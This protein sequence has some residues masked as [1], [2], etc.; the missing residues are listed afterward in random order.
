MSIPQPHYAQRQIGQIAVD[1]PGA[2]A[3][4][5]R[6][7]LDY[8]CG[9]QMSL[10]EAAR[11][12]SIDLQV[13][14]QELAGLGPQQPADH[15]TDPQALIDYIISRFHDAH[16]RDLPELIALSA[17]VERV[18]AGHAEVPVGLS[19]LLQSML[20]ELNLH[21]EKEERILFPLMRQNPGG[22][23]APPIARMREEHED[24]GHLLQQLQQLTHDLHLPA[25]A[26]TTWRALYTGLDRFVTDLMT[27]I[28]T[29]NQVLFPQFEQM[30]AP[31][32]AAH[33][34]AVGGEE[35][36]HII[37]QPHAHRRADNIYP[38][39]ASGIA[40][41]FRHAAIFGA[42]DA[43]E[44]GETMAFFNDHDPLPL[45]RQM[46]QRYRDRLRIE[47]VSRSPDGV[48]I[49]FHRQTEK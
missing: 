43:L 28:N 41:R 19:V 27:H 31:S 3:V 10:E 9:G 42:L 34:G 17:K 14:E 2:T 35:P 20:D 13:I 45:L 12:Q 16:R 25:E 6:H 7:R 44:P 8:C 48:R 33:A 4:F 46:Q 37:Q 29:E 47:Y 26:C 21:M 18:H 30:T 32:A 22:Q 40:K 11:A 15:P 23:L 49:D 36:L 38:F 24:H 39:D 1:I 5:R